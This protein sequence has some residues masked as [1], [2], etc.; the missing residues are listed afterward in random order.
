MCLLVLVNG[1]VAKRVVLGM[2]SWQSRVFASKKEVDKKRLC[3]PSRAFST[4]RDG[5]SG[6]RGGSAASAH[7]AA[8]LAA[9]AL[10]IL[11]SHRPIMYFDPFR[12]W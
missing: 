12:F 8:A 4:D 3:A 5:G 9:A 6:F 11:I 2:I 10:D 7:A 1:R